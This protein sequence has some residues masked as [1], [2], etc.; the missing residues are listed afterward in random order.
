MCSQQVESERV[1]ARAQHRANNMCVNSK[2]KLVRIYKMRVQRVAII[3]IILIRRARSL[4]THHV[5]PATNLWSF[6]RSHLSEIINYLTSSL[7]CRN[8]A[9]LTWE[10]PLAKGKPKYELSLA[11]T[12]ALGKRDFVAHGDLIFFVI[13]FDSRRLI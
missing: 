1:S 3:I 6:K 12:T 7:S 2:K 4:N 5:Q 9:N 10:L 8:G 13:S 11:L